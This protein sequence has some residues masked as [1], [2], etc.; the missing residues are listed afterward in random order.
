[1][2]AVDASGELQLLR[3]LIRDAMADLDTCPKTTTPKSPRLDWLDEWA[4]RRVVM[5]DKA[6][7]ALAWFSGRSL[8]PFGFE[9]VCEHLNLDA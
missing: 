5:G 4:R 1:M 7:N 2:S 9:W 3:S 6:A 8:R